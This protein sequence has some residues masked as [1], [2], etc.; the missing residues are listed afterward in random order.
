MGGIRLSRARKMVADIGGRMSGL[1]HITIPAQILLLPDVND[2]Q[3]MLLGMVSGFSKG[4]HKVTNLTL[5]KLFKV[6]PSRVSDL[7]SDLEGKDYVKILNRQSK[8]RQVL[9]STKLEGVLSTNPESGD[10]TFDE[11]RMHFRPK[12]K[13]NRKKLT[14]ASVNS[15]FCFVLKSGELWFLTK[16][17]LQEYRRTYDGTLDIESELRKAVQWLSDNPS[18]RKTKKGM[19]RFLGGW[20][21]RAKPKKNFEVPFDFEAAKQRERMLAEV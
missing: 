7:L 20:L 4:I 15:D 16:A 8:Y 10:S 13:Q 12:S 9:P 3:K 11:K 5:S 21:S 6:K 14:N 2:K 17:K 18:R 1:T 19:T